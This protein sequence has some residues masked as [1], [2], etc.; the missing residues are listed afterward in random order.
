MDTILGLSAPQNPLQA[1]SPQK[2]C[3]PVNRPVMKVV[4]N[5][6]VMNVVR[7]EWSVMSRSVLKGEPDWTVNSFFW[8]F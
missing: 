7:F 6:P 4:M 1:S 8:S 5:T 3:I 2:S